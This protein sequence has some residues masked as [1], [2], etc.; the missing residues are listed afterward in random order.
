MAFLSV[1]QVDELTAARSNLS[2]QLVPF[3]SSSTSGNQLLGGI[4]SREL[5]AQ[6]LIAEGDE[7]ASLEQELIRRGF[8]KVNVKFVQL[9]LSDQP[10][11]RLHLIEEVLYESSADAR[12]WLLLLADDQDAD[13]RLAVVTILATSNDPALIEKA[14]QVAIRDRDPRIAGMAG[15]LR[16]RRR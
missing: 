14:W 10:D 16:D 1:S 13:V 7:A 3:Q 11:D 8:G 9:L 2:T 5:L 15:R 6:W 12:P 4:H